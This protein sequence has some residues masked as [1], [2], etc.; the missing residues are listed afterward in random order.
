[1]YESIHVRITK[2]QYEWL[3]RYCF[4]NQVSQAEVVRVALEMF[5]IKKEEKVMEKIT[6]HELTEQ[7]S[8]V[9]IYGNEGII[10]NWSSF[11]GLPRLFATGLIDWPA[12]IIERVEG[13]HYEDLSEI[14]DRVEI[15]YGA[16]QPKPKSGKVYEVAT[17]E[18]DK[19][20]VIAPDGWN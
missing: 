15:I 11:S 4:E 17:D 3:R 14:L 5:R 16:D 2:E 20:I 18:S 7:E 6:L 12:S 9:V 1:M 10:C 19:I 13:E 8:G